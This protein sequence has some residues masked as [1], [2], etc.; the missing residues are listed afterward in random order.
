MCLVQALSDHLDAVKA[1]L[2]QKRAKVKDNR[3]SERALVEA[4]VYLSGAL[5]KMDHHP[6]EVTLAASAASCW[7]LPLH[8]HCQAASASAH[9]IG[10][11]AEPMGNPAA[12]VD[13]TRCS[14]GMVCCARTSAAQSIGEGLPLASCAVRADP[15]HSRRRCKG[16][17]AE[18]RQCQDCHAPGLP[19]LPGPVPQGDRHASTVMH[20]H[21]C[22]HAPLQ[23]RFNF[24][25]HRA[26]KVRTSWL[27]T[28]S[29]TGDS[30]ALSACEKRGWLL[31]LPPCRLQVQADEVRTAEQG[32]LM[33]VMASTVEALVVV[34]GRGPDSEAAAL[35]H[36]IAVDPPSAKV[37]LKEVQT[38]LLCSHS[39]PGSHA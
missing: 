20:S 25:S 1:K 2:P 34:C 38:N 19:H 12:E 18:E 8:V 26:I 32:A 21:L 27:A 6:M 29:L 24:C 30:Q 9:G 4:R 17:G 16:H 11:G 39:S 15:A 36:I 3:R 22:S 28:C 37:Q 23:L 13:E 31:R 10:T 7:V 5:F 33:H 14:A 35:E